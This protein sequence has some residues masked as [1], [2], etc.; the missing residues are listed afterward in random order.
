MQ[1]AWRMRG[2]G[3][4]LV[5]GAFALMGA[6]ATHA[7]A[8]VGALAGDARA[9]EPVQATVDADS[10]PASSTSDDALR[11]ASSRFAWRRSSE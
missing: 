10:P 6:F 11:R 3:H 5:I 9:D 7:S 8:D 1:N 4:G 2:R